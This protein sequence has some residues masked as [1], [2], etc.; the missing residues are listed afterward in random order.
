MKK[1]KRDNSNTCLTDCVAYYFNIHTENV[2]FFIGTKSWYKNLKLYFKRRGL[3]IEAVR[4]HK[5]LLTN[6]NKIYLVAG[7]SPRSKAPADGKIKHSRVHH[8]VIYKGSKPHYD[9]A[10]RKKFL[11]GKPMWV[12]LIRK[13]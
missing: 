12:Y 13:L 4:Y 10:G 8:M 9:P 6:K 5:K 1:L 3:V 2:P 11:K 7:L